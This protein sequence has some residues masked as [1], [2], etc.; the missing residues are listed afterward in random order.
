MRLNICCAIPLIA[1]LTSFAACDSQPVGVE[2]MSFM[3][4]MIEGSING[5]YIG[6][7]SFNF[8]SSGPVRFVLSS[9]ATRSTESS[10]QGFWFH[11]MTVPVPGD[12]PI[13]ALS[14]DTY[15]AIYWTCP[16]FV[17]G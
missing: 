5:H 17:D 2:E 13:G 15:R 16:A 12:T 9:K 1:A 3:Q 14:E 7:G 6:S 11:S 8:M 10:D 4:A